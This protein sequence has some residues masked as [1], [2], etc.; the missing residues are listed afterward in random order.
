M[1]KVIILTSFTESYLFLIVNM[2]TSIKLYH[3]FYNITF[4]ISI[5]LSIYWYLMQDVGLSKAA[6]VVESAKT[7]LAT[8]RD[9]ATAQVTSFK[10]E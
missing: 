10:P 5:Y 6:E 9:N 1:I 3:P 7:Y 2:T 8:A 4:E